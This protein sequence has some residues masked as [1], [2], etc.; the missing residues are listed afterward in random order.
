VEYHNELRL[1]HKKSV[2]WLPHCY[3]IQCDF[4]RCKEKVGQRGNNGE[5]RGRKSFIIAKLLLGETSPS[6]SLGLRLRQ[7]ILKYKTG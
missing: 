5:V 6:P 1:P 2:I 3:V 4:C 7:K